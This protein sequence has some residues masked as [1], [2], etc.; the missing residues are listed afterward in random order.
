MSLD[1][2]FA[3]R[4]VVLTGASAGIGRELALQLAPEKP[5]LVLAARDA[6]RLGE[7]ATLAKQA[8]A[9]VLVVPTDVSDP[10][11]CRALV[12]RTIEAWGALDVLLLNAGMSMWT[13]VDV[14]RDPEIFE[15]LMRVNYLGCVWPTFH[16]L[17]HLKRARGRIVV[18]ASVAGLTG[19]P[20]RSGYAATKHALLGFFDSLRIELAGT[21]VTVT[22][23]C[24]DFVVSEIHARSIGADGAPLGESPMQQRKIMST[25]RC[26]AGILAAARARKRL[27]VLS[28]RGKVGRFVRPWAPRLIDWIADRSV[29]R[30]Y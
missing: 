2:S 17:P 5:R 22:E 13:R 29:A 4:V 7:V 3:G 12:E 15:R 26:A 8:G 14:L 25:A 10:D 28:L 11:A 9:Q 21:G 23:V 27:A 6:G 30:G 24:P 16:A 20:T 18:V 1:R 19:V